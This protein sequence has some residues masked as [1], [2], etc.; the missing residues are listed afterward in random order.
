M[1]NAYL[2]T[3][4]KLIAISVLET[5]PKVDQLSDAVLLDVRSMLL[6]VFPSERGAE[7]QES[8]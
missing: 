8:H 3:P 2:V 4:K 5:L 6:A 7:N 1:L